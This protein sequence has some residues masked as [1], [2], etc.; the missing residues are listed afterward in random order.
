MPKT[1]GETAR[2]VPCQGLYLPHTLT[3][4]VKIADDTS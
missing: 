4:D 1:I 3:I 2:I